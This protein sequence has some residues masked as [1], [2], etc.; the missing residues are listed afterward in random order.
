VF[1]ADQDVAGKER[2]ER[3]NLRVTVEKRVLRRVVVKM[4]AKATRSSAAAEK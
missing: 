4:D 3:A 2:R 1:E